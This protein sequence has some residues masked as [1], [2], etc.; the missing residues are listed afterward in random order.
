MICQKI[1]NF[2]VHLLQRQ[3]TPERA[4]PI[5]QKTR[6]PKTSA[7]GIAI[8]TLLIL[9]AP[10]VQ[11]AN[12]TFVSDR[13][14]LGATDRLDW[15]VLGPVQPPFRV[16]PNSFSVTSE[17]GLG[18]NVSIPRA[19]TGGVTPPLLFQTL[20]SP[21]IATN[22]AS[23]DFILLTGLKPGP[24]PAVGNPGPLTIT[25]DRPVAAAGTQIAVDD[26]FL[27]TASISAFDSAN[28][29]LASF[30]T[31]GTSS[32]ALDNSA[33]FLGVR[34]DVANI[35]RLVY[36]S[37]ENNRALGINALSIAEAVPEPSNIAAT[38]VAGAG[39]ALF[40]FKLK[41]SSLSLNK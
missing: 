19:A 25:F 9:L 15:S 4:K 32:L 22:F 5:A 20:P 28:N 31:Q 26:V 24:P 29:L 3:R 13:A 1:Q 34:S 6:S 18:I 30:S 21:G 2:K 12:L 10:P 16:L 39:L 40:A 8:A 41:R 37:S 14:T 38:A 17:Q 23:G 35:S 27:F 7:A 11:A 33:Q 36:S